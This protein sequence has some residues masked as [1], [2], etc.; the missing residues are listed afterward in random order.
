M[1]ADLEMAKRGVSYWEHFRALF[2]GLRRWQY[3]WGL[4]SVW[5]C[6]SL[7]GVCTGGL[8]VVVLGGYKWLSL[9]ERPGAVVA[10]PSLSLP[11]EHSD[12]GVFVL[13]WCPVPSPDPPI[14]HEHEE[15]GRRSLTVMNLMKAIKMKLRRAHAADSKH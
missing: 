8:Q 7:L 9:V 11:V 4:F 3:L 14:L 2:Q 5:H 12:E 10:Q 13:P 6:S 1:G 15:L